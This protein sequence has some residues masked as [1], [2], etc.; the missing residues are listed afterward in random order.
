[1]T[2]LNQQA[3]RRLGAGGRSLPFASG[4]VESRA[5]R[6]IVACSVANSPRAGGVDDQRTG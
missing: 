2:A 1:M 3:A 5:Q 6:Y 4:E